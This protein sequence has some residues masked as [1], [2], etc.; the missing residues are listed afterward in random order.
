MWNLQLS[1]KSFEWMWLWGWVVKTYFDP[2]YI[3][4]GVRTPSTSPWST[5]P[6][7]QSTRLFQEQAHKA[8]IDGE[9]EKTVISTSS[10]F[11][12]QTDIWLKYPIVCGFFMPNQQNNG[13]FQPYVRV[14][15][16]WSSSWS[17]SVLYIDY[18]TVVSSTFRFVLNFYTACSLSLAAQCIVIGPV[19]GFVYGCVCLFVGLLP[20]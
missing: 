12:R 4:S 10:F 8:Q 14:C 13:I 7:N 15:V 1:N 5:R 6:C 3:F 18:L 19:C 16:C 11:S 17:S 2:S 20:R 9:I